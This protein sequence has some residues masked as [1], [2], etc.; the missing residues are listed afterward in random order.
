[1]DENPNL[2]LI[3][4]EHHWQVEIK[5]N[6]PKQYWSADTKNKKLIISNTDVD[7]SK[8]ACWLQYHNYGR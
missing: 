7:Y 6:D 8:R 3:I 4:D 1:M 5:K 2:E